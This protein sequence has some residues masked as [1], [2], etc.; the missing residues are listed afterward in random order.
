MPQSGILKKKNGNNTI[1]NEHS[2]T[3][4]TKGRKK[5]QISLRNKKADLIWVCSISGK[6]AHSRRLSNSL[7]A[8]SSQKSREKKNMKQDLKDI[9]MRRIYTKVFVRESN[10]TKN[11]LESQSQRMIAFRGA[12]CGKRIF[13]TDGFGLNSLLYMTSPNQILK[14]ERGYLSAQTERGLEYMKG[15]QS[16]TARSVKDC[17]E[18][19]IV[20]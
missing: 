3:I 9:Y 11:I 12:S 18:W 5:F 15:W 4:V 19:F 6:S 20:S 17:R 1:F 10:R 13:P 2:V 7:R 14:I 16:Q 8:T